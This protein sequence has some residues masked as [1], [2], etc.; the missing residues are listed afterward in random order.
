MA[1]VPGLSGINHFVVV[2]LE[3]R[4]FDQMLGFLYS[5]SGNVSP[6]GQPFEGLTGKE[7]NP[8]GKGGQV[9]V[10]PIQSSDPNA[11]FV[12]GAVPGEDYPSTNAQLFGSAQA[13][14]PVPPATNQGF[15]TNFAYMIPERSRIPGMALPGT[16]PAD[17]MRV[18]TPQTVPILSGLAAGYAVCDHWH[19]S[20]PTQTFPNRAFVAMATS[21]GFVN[22]R[23]CP[24]QF[25]APSIFTALSK[26]QQG[27]AVYGYDKPPLTRGSVADITSADPSH[28]GEFPDF[29]KAASQGSLASYVFLEPQWGS[30]GSSQ[31][32][33]YNVALGE[34]FLK[35]VYTALQ[36]SPLWSQT[37][38]I[39]TYDEHGGCY[40]H[41]PP[42][43]TAVA[44]DA[45]A[46][47]MGFDFKRFGVRVPAVL[48]SPFIAKGTVYRASGTTPLD[49]TSVLATLEKRYGIPPLTRRDAAAPDVGGVLT[50][51]KARA[52]DPLSGV[53]PPA[54]KPA[55]AAAHAPDPLEEALADTAEI[56]PI[57]DHPGAGFSHV[58]PPLKTSEDVQRYARERYGAYDQWLRKSKKN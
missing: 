20:V 51:G 37:L 1:T 48:V 30:G 38:L 39:I 29:Q 40:D 56:L 52:D 17:I 34:A 45:S 13:P 24:K 33:N 57:P 58:R 2:M 6:L 12:P 50:L 4:S 26:K 5:A 47:E 15:V 16:V 46:G 19:S 28:F 8:D 31:H 21:Q 55:P 44:P 7:T 3:N 36:G 35:Q 11:Y 18:H 54:A 27:W 10:R 9:K 42:P 23:T 22:D 49:H 53:S 14:V 43:Q 32:P 25:T 41:V